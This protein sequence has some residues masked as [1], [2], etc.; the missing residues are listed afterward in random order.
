MNK[1]KMN[2]ATFERVIEIILWLI[3]VVCTLY[4]NW[5]SFYQNY[6]NELNIKIKVELSEK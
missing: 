1:Y 5:D 2:E 4:C 3:F 6:K